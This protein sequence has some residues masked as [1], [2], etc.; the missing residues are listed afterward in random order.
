[1]WNLILGLLLI[2]ATLDNFL[3][4]FRADLGGFD[5]S[6][7]VL[8]NVIVLAV[9]LLLLSRNKAGAVLPGLIWGPFLFMTAISMAYAPDKVGA[10]KLFGAQLTYFAFFSFPF[11][12]PRTATRDDAIVDVL[13]LSSI[14]PLLYGVYEAAT[15]FNSE[16]RAQSTFPHSNI[17]AFYLLILM[18]GIV[19]KMY[20]R[21]A[22]R[23]AVVTTV[24]ICLLLAAVAFLLLTQTRSAW[25]AFAVMFGI[26]ALFVDRRLLL[27]TVLIPALLL[28]PAVQ[29]RL[30]DTSSS[31]DVAQGEALSSYAWRQRLWEQAFDDLEGHAVFGKG[32]GSFHIN[33][34]VFSDFT[35][36]DGS[37]TEAHNAYVQTIY[38]S[39]WV[40]MAAFALV[41]LSCIASLLKFWRVARREAAIGI[42]CLTAMMIVNYSDNTP[43]YLAYN[44]YAWSLVAFIIC[45]CRSIA[46]MPAVARPG[47]IA[48]RVVRR[49]NLRQL[50]T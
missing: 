39:G 48:Q 21:S 23:S 46:A 42:A 22:S 16:F 1:M 47:L 24:Y 9:L 45:K 33:S 41:F 28:V 12:L 40:G 11:L 49:A 37:T 27:A 2:R 17:F 25:I 36:A 3:G 19:Y 30:E 5:F 50:P 13:L 7:G 18:G 20:N 31:T 26:I 29:S 6:P 44:W 43:Y 32:L 34:G 38:E 15:G 35:I 14:V 4:D 8:L 10:I